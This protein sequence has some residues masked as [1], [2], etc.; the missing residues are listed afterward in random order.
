MEALFAIAVR[1]FV[2]FWDL[3]DFVEIGMFATV[4]GATVV[5]VVSEIPGLEVAWLVCG[6][7][8]CG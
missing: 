3:L 7:S 1:V 4:D 8:F 6:W 5:T 2:D